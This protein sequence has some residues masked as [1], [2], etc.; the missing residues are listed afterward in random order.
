MTVWKELWEGDLVWQGSWGYL[1]TRS[2]TRRDSSQSVKCLPVEAAAGAE[3]PFAP[4]LLNPVGALLLVPE[5]RNS[6]DGDQVT[7]I[8]ELCKSARILAGG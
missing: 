5:V 3:R 2:A 4:K 7:A 6:L 1:V 8:T